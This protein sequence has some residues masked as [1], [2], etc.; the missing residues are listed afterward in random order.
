MSKKIENEFYD[1]DETMCSRIK[2]RGLR[3]MDRSSPIYRLRRKVQIVAHKLFSDEFMSKLYFRIVMRRN[4][5][6]K[7]PITFNEKLQWC[8]LY[9]FPY[10]P[11]VVQCADKYAVRRHIEK[12]GYGDKLVPLLGSWDKAEDIDWDAL[13]DRFVLKCN[14]GCAYNIICSDKM[15][16]D[17]AATIKQLNGWLREDFGA[18]NIEPHYSKISPRKIICEQFL[19]ETIMDYKFFCF[20]GE[21][22]CIYV[23]YNLIHDRQAQIGFF[24]L[25]GSKVPLKRND[26][27]DIPSVQLPVFYYEMI[28]MAKNLCQDFPFVR[29]DFFLANNTYYFAEFTFTPGACMMPF[30]SDKYD[31]EWGDMLRLPSGGNV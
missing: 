19:G 20:N 31:N 27:S 6:L 15:A 7:N 13:P 30:N 18:F 9:Y 24:Y 2:M 21:P 26:Y 8:K 11:L 10:D 25:D 16:L 23:S 4:L 29:I 1:L 28:D 22:K 14:H 12:E 3:E 17:R 5:N